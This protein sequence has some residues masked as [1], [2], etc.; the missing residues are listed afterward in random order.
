[1]P[2]TNLPN[3]NSDRGFLPGFFCGLLLAFMALPPVLDRSYV[4]TDLAIVATALVAI[5]SQRHRLPRPGR[6]LPW[7]FA[8]GLLCVLFMASYFWGRWWSRPL[9]EP[10]PPGVQPP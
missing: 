1:M 4:L 5:L 10:M 9:G 3:G 8:S 6:T 2:T 7:L